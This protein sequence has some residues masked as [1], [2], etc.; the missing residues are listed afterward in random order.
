MDCSEQFKDAIELNQHCLNSVHH[1]LYK[2]FI[3]K[4]TLPHYRAR[5][6]RRGG[7]SSLSPELDRYQPRPPR[8]RA[9]FA[10][11]YHSSPS[12]YCVRC[13]IQFSSPAGL[14]WHIRT[15]IKHCHDQA[16]GKQ[17]KEEVTKK[18][19][20][21]SSQNAL[22]T[23]PPRTPL[24]SLKRAAP[25]PRPPTPQ[26]S[27]DSCCK[28]C[29]KHF[30]SSAGLNSHIRSKHRNKTAAPEHHGDQTKDKEVEKEMEKT[31]KRKKNTQTAKAAAPPAT[32]QPI[33]EPMLSVLQPPPPIAFEK[34]AAATPIAVSIPKTPIIGGHDS[35]PVRAIPKQSPPLK[36]NEAYCTVCWKHFSSP[37]GLDSH[38]RASRKH[39]NKAAV[40]GQHDAQME[41]KEVE[42]GAKEKK[43]KSHTEPPVPTRPPVPTKPPA[44]SQLTILRLRTTWRLPQI[45]P[46]QQTVSEPVQPIPWPPPPQ[47]LQDN[48]TIV[49]TEL[50][51]PRPQPA[52]TLR[53]VTQPAQPIL[54]PPPPQALEDNGTTIST[55]LP[56]SRPQPAPTLQPATQPVKLIPQPP[57]LQVN[58]DTYCAVCKQRF[59]SSAGLDSHI[60][61]KKHRRKT[62]A[63]EKDDA[64]VKATDVK[65]DPETKKAK[66]IRATISTAPL[67]PWPQ[68]MPT[69]GATRRPQP[70]RTAQP[71]PA[72]VHP[73]LHLQPQWFGNSE[74]PISMAPP[75]PRQQNG[76]W[77]R[78]VP[79][80]QTLPTSPSAVRP[81]VDLRLQNVL[82]SQDALWPQMAPW[83]QMVPWPQ[84]AQQPQAAPPVQPVSNLVQSMPY[85]SPP[86]AFGGTYCPFCQKYFPS[87]VELDLHIHISANHRNETAGPPPSAIQNW[88]A[89][90]GLPYSAGLHYR[91]QFAARFPD[92]CSHHG[93]Y[94][95]HPSLQEAWSRFQIAQTEDFETMFGRELN[96]SE[97]WRRLC[98]TAGITIIP[99][100]LEG[101]HQ[102]GATK[103]C[104]HYA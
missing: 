18:K 48:G 30:S 41:C 95:G 68:P 72:P 6:I 16:E 58:N 42:E 57:P 55:E 98:Q 69:L 2:K 81:R 50:P 60:L 13:Q 26:M 9:Q 45:T 82:R 31:E 97:A 56:A 85:L 63:S 78:T 29:K 74:T 47:A 99:S 83:S 100:D 36:L 8:V 67:T 76:P 27:D 62:T 102:V 94:P 37:V 14:D 53:P 3:S 96:D 15:S 19:Q 61:S 92:L 32:L 49:S 21:R 66:N 4:S 79:R 7:S 35:E 23:P 64:Q 24:L 87:P 1:S 28:L 52:P 89:A 84:T 44:P 71:I 39:R 20:T 104:T 86:H 10:S 80:P 12:P 22:H 51:P 101:R 103:P 90:H 33:S 91:G 40:S 43:E 17:D 75:A 77:L 11:T 5:A 54:Q 70:S 38:I 88:F 25:A 65:E 59:S 73:I 34:S 93:W 46:T